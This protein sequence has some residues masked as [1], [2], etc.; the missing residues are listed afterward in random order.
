MTNS[1]IRWPLILA[2]LVCAGCGGHK[3]RL[4]TWGGS[5]LESSYTVKIVDNRIAESDIVRLQIETDE[6]LAGISR[7]NESTSTADQVLALLAR[8]G[9]SNACV[10]IGGKVVM[11]G[12]NLEG[13]PWRTNHP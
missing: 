2:V 7:S 8:N 6:L 11:R 10:E 13:T 12:I 9:I 1:S 3:P 4:W 5:A